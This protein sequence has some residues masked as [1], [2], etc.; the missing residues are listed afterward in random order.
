MNKEFIDYCKSLGL[1]AELLGRVQALHLMF[2]AMFPDVI[3][4]IFIGDVIEPDG[5]RNYT[6]VTFFSQHF[7]GTANSFANNPSSFIWPDPSFSGFNFGVEDFAWTTATEKSRLVFRC[8]TLPGLASLELRA[9]G[10][11]CLKLVKIIK[12]WLMRAR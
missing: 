4:D 5:T 6:G 10:Q 9:S 12:D 3:K 2:V 11:N 8:F 1:G 7:I